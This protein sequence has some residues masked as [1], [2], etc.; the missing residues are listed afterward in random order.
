MISNADRTCIVCGKK[1]S[2]CPHCGADQ[3]KPSWMFIFDD[4]CCHDVYDAVSGYKAGAYTKEQAKDIIK[5]H[6]LNKKINDNMQKSVDE[7][8]TEEKTSEKTVLPK[9]QKEKR[10]VLKDKIDNE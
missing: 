3:N 9:M 5:K 10:T 4:E 2:F 6:K 1:Y 8:L 7:I